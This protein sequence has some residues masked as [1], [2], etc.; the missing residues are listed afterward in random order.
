VRRDVQLAVQHA[1]VDVHGQLQQ[2][3][4]QRR[5]QAAAHHG[6]QQVVALRR[7]RRPAVHHA[8][9]QVAAARLRHHSR[10]GRP[11]LLQLLRQQEVD[12]VLQLGLAALQQQRLQ[13]QR[14][15]AAMTAAAR[16]GR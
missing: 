12:G 5:A 4:H 7:R 16:A 14:R 1:R 13:R 6:H 3:L 15:A 2:P 9:R 8:H 11:V 10:L